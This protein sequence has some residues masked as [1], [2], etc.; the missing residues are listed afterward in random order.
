MKNK[1]EKIRKSVRLSDG[2]AA[3]LK[4]NA[5]LCGLTETEYMRQ[6]I[7]GMQPKALPGDRFWDK[8]NELYACHSRLRRRA[9]Q[10]ENDPALHKVYADKADELQELVVKIIERYTQPD[11]I[12]TAENDYSSLSEFITEQDK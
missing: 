10:F 7:L 1:E 8:M 4:A 11:F 5:A 6:L 9:K 3:T 12:A 2:E